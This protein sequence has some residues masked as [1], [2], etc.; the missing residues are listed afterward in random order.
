MTAPSEH[1]FEKFKKTVSNP[2]AYIPTAVLVIILITL[3]IA[4][5]MTLNNRN[6]NQNDVTTPGTESTAFPTPLPTALPTVD[7]QTTL[8][9]ETTTG[10]SSDPDT[11]T[12]VP[13]TSPGT[14]STATTPTT[15]EL[16]HEL[17]FVTRET[18]LTKGL[19]ISGR[20]K[21]ITPVSK[22][23]LSSTQSD[24]CY[25]NET[26]I[27]FMALRQLHAYPLHDDVLENFLIDASGAV[28]EG[29]GFQKEGQTTGES[30]TSYNSK[31][32]SISF[33]LSES[34]STP[35]A[36]QQE[37]FCDFVHQSIERGSLDGNYVV[38]KHYALLASYDDTED[39]SLSV[40]ACELN[41]GKRRINFH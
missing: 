41:W 1:K 9:E 15:T 3:I 12:E 8:A 39:D 4:V 37:S 16:P 40:G 25:D 7:D 17:K 21:Q 10:S 14:T 23:I 33:I 30:G 27:D 38:F 24:A 6:Q 18:W 29:R 26:C 19:N 20:Y 2:R 13:N 31:A 28:Y 11:D 36:V 32:V 34:E 5:P 22:I 35:S